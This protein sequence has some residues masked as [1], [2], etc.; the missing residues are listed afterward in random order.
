MSSA[1]LTDF[2]EDIEEKMARELGLDASKLKLM[3]RSTQLCD[4][5]SLED[6]GVK[7]ETNIEVKIHLADGLCGGADDNPEPNITKHPKLSEKELLS[8]AAEVPDIYRK[9]AVNLD[10]SKS[11]VDQIWEDHH[12]SGVQQVVF[13][14]L[15]KWQQSQSNSSDFRCL[16][17]DALGKCGR[18][19][20]AEKVLEGTVLK[21]DGTRHIDLDVAQC[22]EELR[23]TYLNRICH[24]PKYPWDETDCISINDIYTDLSLILEQPTPCQPLKIPLKDQD[25]VFTHETVCGNS[26]T[27]IIIQGEAGTGKSTLMVKYVYDW[28]REDDLASSPIR[29]FKLVF[30]LRLRDLEESSRLEEA[31]MKHLLPHDTKIIASQLRSF[32]EDHPEDCCVILDGYD[33]FRHSG[34]ASAAS[35]RSIVQ[36]INNDILRKC[37]LILS[38]RPAKLSDLGKCLKEYKQFEVSGFSK[39]KIKNYINKF[40]GLK[41][42]LASSLIDYIESNNLD[43]GFAAAPLIT[44]L[45]CLY[46]LND[47]KS[48]D[49]KTVEATLSVSKLHLTLFDFLEQH[50]LAKQT[51]DSDFDT[52]ELIRDLGRVA[53][54]SLWPPN[55]QLVFAWKEMV[56]EIGDDNVTKACAVGLLHK[57]EATQSKAYHKATK[58][59][60]SLSSWKKIS[61]VEFFHTSAQEKCGGEYL[62]YLSEHKEEEFNIFMQALKAPSDT[63]NAKM[64]LLFACGASE[65]AAT[66]ILRHL[67]NLFTREFQPDLEQ[68]FKGELH[69]ERSK[70][71]QDIVDLC[72]MCNFECEAT[73]H[74]NKDLLTLFP[75]GRIMFS[76]ITPQRASALSYFLSNVRCPGA[77]KSITVIGVPRKGNF[78]VP[79]ETMQS[80]SDRTFHKYLE[81]YSKLSGEELNQKLQ[82][83]ASTC[84]EVHRAADIHGVACALAS[85]QMWQV[86]QDWQKGVNFSIKTLINSLE[87]IQTERLMVRSVPLHESSAVLWKLIEDRKLQE[88]T[89]LNLRQTGLEVEDVSKLA[90]CVHLL[91][92]L[93]HL[94][95]CQNEKAG[96]ALDKLSKSLSSINLEVLDVYCM[97]ATPATMKTVHSNLPK[98]GSQMKELYL[99]VNYMD[100]EGANILAENLSQLKHLTLINL[101]HPD[102]HSSA[103]AMQRVLESIA[104]LPHLQ[105]V[106]LCAGNLDVQS[107]LRILAPELKKW[108]N[109]K[110]MRIAAV[111]ECAK[112]MVDEPQSQE[113]VKAIATMPNL[114]TLKLNGIGLT[115]KSFDELVRIG[116]EKKFQKL[117][118][119]C[120]SFLPDDYKIPDDDFVAIL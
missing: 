31:I 14:M 97:K 59:K 34:L 107:C 50:Y 109:I 7:N 39:N 41:K 100:E 3:M 72:L 103:A 25:E 115:V 45:L 120:R 62:A 26:S 38:S 17:A 110:E 16:L 76:G 56:T 82:Q 47:A 67:A 74:L 69:F 94:D 42:E 66:L 104:L 30:L 49:S 46:W 21:P 9:L 89:H 1:G 51:T 58:R 88:L 108:Q 57:H 29:K 111:K 99:H 70:S 106:F 11:T 113:F 80:T 2:S 83:F 48:G 79:T 118:W 93:K 86:F 114:H 12:H 105:I 68:F 54:K 92:K 5:L 40:F 22:Q 102:H 8:L 77:I 32:I 61:T 4:A 64:I 84:S 18:V 27:R 36:M 13:V 81:A 116:R 60:S 101:P 53:L 44:Q 95:I 28:A 24:L 117:V 98:F 90:E 55:S 35:D 52:E 85:M 65:K 73:G 15:I 33:E 75:E 119:Y 10:V 71:I 19:D 23:W 78:F 96:G 6:N 91:P 63:L 112:K 87:N 20:M 43:V 37:F